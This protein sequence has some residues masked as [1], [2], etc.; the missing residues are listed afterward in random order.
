MKNT[1]MSVARYLLLPGA[2]SAHK[3]KAAQTA[4]PPSEQMKKILAIRPQYMPPVIDSVARIEQEIAAD[5][6]AFEALLS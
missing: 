6:A 2:H 5:E 3:K 4:G 1:G